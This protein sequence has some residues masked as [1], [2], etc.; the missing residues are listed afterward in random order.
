M[1]LPSRAKSSRANLLIVAAAALTLLA[2]CG[3]RGALEAPPGAATL[4]TNT[5]AVDEQAQGE[6]PVTV[7]PVGKSNSRSA[8][9]TAPQR[10]FIL[11]SIL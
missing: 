10:P 11:D 9:I 6:T 8:P 4:P 5:S 7:S 3:R 1:P 2:A